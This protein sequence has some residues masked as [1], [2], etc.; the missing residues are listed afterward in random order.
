M[1]EIG[2]LGTLFPKNSKFRNYDNYNKTV[3]YNY[4][5]M[6]PINCFDHKNEYIVNIPKNIYYVHITI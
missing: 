6:K 3:I 4:W 2:N 1:T 5:G